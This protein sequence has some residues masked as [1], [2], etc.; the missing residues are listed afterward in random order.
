MTIEKLFKIFLILFNHLHS[1]LDFGIPIPF[2]LE[3]HFS[4]TIG[5]PNN[6][7]FLLQFL[8]TAFKT[9]TKSKT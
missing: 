1:S 2:V 9:F 3:S 4:G 8:V 6:I 5:N 7:T